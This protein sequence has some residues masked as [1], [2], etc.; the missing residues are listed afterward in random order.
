M[1]DSDFDVLLVSRLQKIA[2]TL[3]SKGKEYGD[4]DRLHNFK[5]AAI[6]IGESV[7]EAWRGMFVKHYVSVNDMIEGR[8]PVTRHYI[9]EKIGDAI[10]YLILLE[11]ILTES[12]DEEK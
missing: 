5:D 7:A 12:L 1:T 11:A 10:N 4:E 9:D 6:I 2:K 3:A 8:L